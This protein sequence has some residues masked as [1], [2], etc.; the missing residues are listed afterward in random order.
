MGFTNLPVSVFGD[1]TDVW[2][3]TNQPAELGQIAFYKTT[4]GL[5]SLL[6]YCEATDGWTKG[7]VLVHDA[8]KNDPA[9]LETAATGDGGLGN[10]RGIGAATVASASRGWVY[11]GGYCPAVSMPTNFASGQG[12]RISAT[13]AGRLSSAAINA[14]GG[15]LA[16]TSLIYTVAIALESATVS[17]ANSFGS[18]NIVGVYL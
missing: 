14:T 13:Y 10:F 3:S 11:V 5:W 7:D 1:V 15:T 6:K 9:N 12:M 8:A 18:C 2:T 16:G 17:T 4:G